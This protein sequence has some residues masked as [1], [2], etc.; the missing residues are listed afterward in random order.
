MGLLHPGAVRVE[1]PAD[2]LVL[3]HNHPSV[4]FT[5]RLGHR[6]REPAWFRTRLVGEAV[7]V[8]P[9]VVFTWM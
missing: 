3:A 6:L 5:D 9:E 8:V 1:Q 7:E 4:E 2:H